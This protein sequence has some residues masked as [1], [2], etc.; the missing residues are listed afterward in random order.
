M[1]VVDEHRKGRWGRGVGCRCV[2]MEETRQGLMGKMCGAAD[3]LLD[4]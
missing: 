4:C 2:K 1:V 3:E